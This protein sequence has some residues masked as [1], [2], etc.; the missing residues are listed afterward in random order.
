MDLMISSQSSGNLRVTCFFCSEAVRAALF[1]ASHHSHGCA[2]AHN[3][4]PASE[5]HVGRIHGMALPGTFVTAATSSRRHLIN[6]VG[7]GCQRTSVL[8]NSNIWVCLCRKPPTP[9]S[10]S[11]HLHTVCFAAH[12]YSVIL[13]D[14]HSYRGYSVR[15]YKLCEC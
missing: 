12:C 11:I 15:F 4:H 3:Q 1:D 5:R 13:K 2:A 9:T 14:S 10:P 8:S 7:C 6:G